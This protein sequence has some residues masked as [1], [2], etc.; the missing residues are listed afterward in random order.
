MR[1]MWLVPFVVATA[2]F[3]GT[4]WASAVT[5]RGSLIPSPQ[6]TWVTQDPVQVTPRRSSLSPDGA[7][8]Y[9]VGQISGKADQLRI[10]RGRARRG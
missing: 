2:V 1:R 3:V 8:A 9:V 4:P 6:P 7:T 10:L 5:A